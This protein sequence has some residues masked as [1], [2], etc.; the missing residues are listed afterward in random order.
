M[1]LI[2]RNSS[3]SPL[4]LIAALG[5]CALHCSPKD[6]GAPGE[7]ADDASGGA[8]GEA[9]I[10]VGGTGGRP[11]DMGDNLGGADGNGNGPVGQ[12][13][14]LFVI[15]NSVSMADKQELLKEA[16]PD[17]IRRLVDPPCVGPAGAVPATAEGSCPDGT[18]REFDPVDDIHMGVIS[19]SLGG[20][21]A[22]LCARNESGWDNDDQA[23]LISTVRDGLPDDGGLGFLAWQ[24]GA[25]DAA[26]QFIQDFADQVAAVGENGCGYE[27][28]LEAWY[29]FLVDP[30]P[31]QEIV[32]DESQRAKMATGL[33]GNPL[34]D[35][36]VLA[37]REA[38]LRP[39]SLVN[40]II[41]TD[42]NDCSIMDGGT[43]YKNAGY[44]YLISQPT[45][46][47]PLATPECETNPNDKCCFSCLQAQLPPEGCEESAS[48]CEDATPS[49]E[50]D[51]A[52]VRCF[53]NK[54]RFGLDL[55]Y[56]TDRY[57]DALSNEIIVDARTS[58]MVKNPLLTGA[59][60][61]NA[62]RV[63]PKGLVY[64]TGIIG[65]P[66]QDIATPESLVE[67]DV[68]EYLTAEQ[69]AA[70]FELD[71]E[72]VDRWDVILGK[73]GLA[74]SDLRCQGDSPPSECGATP[75]PPLDPF[76]IES[77]AQR[78]EGAE[79][80]ISGD[81]IVSASSN[82]PSANQING[83]ETDNA[84]IDKQRYPAGD[85]S[86][87]V[88]DELQYAC[89]FP[90][91]TPKEDCSPFETGCDCGDEPLRNRAV[92]QPPEGGAATTTQ[93]FGKAY[94]GLRILEVLRD[95]GDNS[96]V[97]SICPK[98]SDDGYTPVVTTIITRM[99]ERLSAEN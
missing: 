37:Q 20:H 51:R 67:P 24:G 11:D 8:E 12:V 52:N 45:F 96:V 16:V 72:V 69:L 9:M 18:V 88:N 43:Y 70:P 14:L 39:E 61:S 41:L 23:H 59:G 95:F 76:M 89:I 47:M 5:A 78:P 87:V 49:S 10:S 13:D 98:L 65:V 2:H 44:G 54:R 97:G 25:P 63:R 53:E 17:M 1:N 22:T 60:P 77:I 27:A 32:L 80:P 62:G 85:D 58:E 50:D 46:D 6:G 66:W 15:D 94:P 73:P 84:V 68:L 55:L 31:P 48:I 33:D 21:G 29:R 3:K 86:G 99:K 81:V 4:W 34:V 40:I 93:Y 91:K 83:H 74:M 92:C 19:S 30:Q 35:E 57:V 79:N 56:P 42:E 7:P 64:L 90:L 28:P 75:V 36:V 38:F 26:S 71:G 82:N